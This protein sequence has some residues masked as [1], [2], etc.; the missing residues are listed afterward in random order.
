MLVTGLKALQGELRSGL[1]AQLYLLFTRVPPLLNAT[2]LRSPLPKSSIDL[3]WQLA[4]Q[5]A[6]F[7]TDSQWDV[8]TTSAGHYMLQDLPPDECT[9]ENAVQDGRSVQKAVARIC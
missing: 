3:S 7:L 4:K 2:A 8:E 6:I 1:R 5:L 9:S